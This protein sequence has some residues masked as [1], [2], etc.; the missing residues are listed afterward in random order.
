MI[1]LFIREHHSDSVEQLALQRNRYKD[2]SD[3]QFRWALQQIEGWQR[4]RDKLPEIA[5][6]IDWWYPVRLSCEQA[7]SEPTARFKAKLVSGDSM[8]DLTGG[9]GIDT[10]YIGQQFREVT[11]VE[12]NEELCRL[13]HH[14]LPHA[15][16]LNM[17]AE[18]Y[19]ASMPLMDLV[20]LDPARRN[21]QGSKVFRLQDCTPDL[22]QLLPL[23]RY[24]TLLVKLSPM[25]DLSALHRAMPM[26]GETYV[27]ALSGEVKEVLFL[28]GELALHPGRISAIDLTYGYSFCFTPD[29]ETMATPRWADHVMNYIYEPSPAILK[30][31]AY[32]LLSDRYGVDQLDPNTHLY[33]SDQ[34]VSSFPG[35]IWRY[36]PD[37][38]YRDITQANVLTRNYPISA[39]QLR[40]QLHIKD[41]GDLYIIGVRM[42]GHK[43][44]LC[45]EREEI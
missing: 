10:Y 4:T 45:A 40:A 38:N 3:D 11:Y 12:H 42:R 25:L 13:A 23:L 5:A 30:A 2:L 1:D 20:Y 32:H 16:V 28:S 18:A 7:S 36:L 21:L 14:N 6:R 35:R 34:L 19:A 15:R 43:H 37:R 9:A 44:I 22:T 29:E 31:G 41:G 26:P 33:T 27:L 24:R 39:D 8:V 17:E